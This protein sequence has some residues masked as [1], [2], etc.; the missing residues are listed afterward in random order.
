MLKMKLKYTLS[1]LLSAI[2]LFQFAAVFATASSPWRD[3]PTVEFSGYH[4]QVKEGYGAPGQN[5]WSQENVRVDAEGRLHLRLNYKANGWYCAEIRSVEW[6][7]Y[8][9]F[10]FHLIANPAQLDPQVVLGMFLYNEL[11][12][13]EIDVEISRWGKDAGTNLHYS[14]HNCIGTVMAED[15][16]LNLSEG[17]FSTHRIDWLADRIVYSS[18]YGHRQ[19]TRGLIFQKI[20]AASESEDTFL[21]NGKMRVHLNLWLFRGNAPDPDEDVEVIFRRFIYLSTGA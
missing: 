16:L 14:L 21:P 9:S 7:G 5:R 18:Q 19:D 11:S 13:N 20:V 2:H 15:F 1:V 4:W 8:G 12:Q 17:D 6:F 3:P 10:L